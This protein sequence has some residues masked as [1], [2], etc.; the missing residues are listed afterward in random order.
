LGATGG[1]FANEG[2]AEGVKTT[3]VLVRGCRV[4]IGGVGGVGAV[5]WGG[6]AGG[7]RGEVA[8][9]TELR[10]LR[11]LAEL[12]VAHAVDRAVVPGLV[13]H[14]LL[15]RHLHPPHC[16]GPKNVSPRYVTTARNFTGCSS[17]SGSVV[18]VATTHGIPIRST[19]PGGF[20]P[21]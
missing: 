18:V 4:E 12:E 5:V 17:P 7:G 15:L 1:R 16:P 11:F 9:Q 10:L 13:Y 3:D 21:A 19:V 8:K 14:L 6:A 2:G 20:D